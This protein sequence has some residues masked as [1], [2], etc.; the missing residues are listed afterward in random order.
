M[1]APWA[2]IPEF[3][4]QMS[5]IQKALFNKEVWVPVFAFGE[6]GMTTN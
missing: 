4:Q 5:G 1:R 6:T 2:V 3:A